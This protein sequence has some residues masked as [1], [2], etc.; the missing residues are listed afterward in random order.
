M[1]RY[2]DPSPQ[3]LDWSTCSLARTC[4]MPG[5]KEEPPTLHSGA[6]EMHVLPLRAPTPW[7]GWA[8]WEWG[9]QSAVGPFRGEPGR[10]SGS[11][12]K[13]EAPLSLSGHQLGVGCHL[14]LSQLIQVSGLHS[15]GNCSNRKPT[16]GVHGKGAAPGWGR[17]L[18]GTGLQ[19]G[20]PTRAGSHRTEEDQTSP[21]RTAPLPW[22]D[23]FLV[24][25]TLLSAC[26]S[27]YFTQAHHSPVCVPGE[28]RAPVK[29]TSPQRLVP[30]STRTQVPSHHQRPT[31][32]PAS[33]HLLQ[34]RTK[35]PQTS[36]A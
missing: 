27:F 21:R 11:V 32:P 24:I 35:V 5:D 25:F 12:P 1:P 3:D 2:P 31:R 19:R 7:N 10:A 14:S 4:S 28:T 34:I 36:A 26:H 33:L 6:P 30:R 9:L 16:G 15:E 13:S 20:H 29:R 18:G 8:G 17:P 23:W 22:G